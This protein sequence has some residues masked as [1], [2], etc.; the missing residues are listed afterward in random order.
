[1]RIENSNNVNFGAYFKNNALFKELY[2]SY[3][4]N[5]DKNLIDTFTKELPNHEIEI[6][7]KWDTH[8]STHSY[9][10]FFNNNTGASRQLYREKKENILNECLKY[11]INLPVN[12]YHD[13]WGQRTADNSL[14][15]NYK[16]LTNQNDR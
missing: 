8:P 5:V 13:F 9:Y 6:I 7:S 4:K 11:F 14:E 15:E 16:A 12:G 2:Q 1:M 10:T 3:G